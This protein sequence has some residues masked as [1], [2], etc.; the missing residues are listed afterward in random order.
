MS[1]PLSDSEFAVIQSA[2]SVATETLAVLRLQTIA[3][4]MYLL[5]KRV[6]FVENTRLALLT[7]IPERRSAC[8]SEWSRL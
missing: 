3:I 7:A 2:R 6:G 4:S 8:F 5:A 1:H